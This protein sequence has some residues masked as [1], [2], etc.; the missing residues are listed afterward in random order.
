VRL[1][2]FSLVVS[3]VI[4]GGLS[5]WQGWSLSSGQIGWWIALGL[6]YSLIWLLIGVVNWRRAVGAQ[7][8]FQP[9][10][11]LLIGRGGLQWADQLGVTWDGLSQLAIRR[12]LFGGA[13][14]LDITGQAG[15]SLSLNLDSLD[16]AAGTIDSAVESLSGGTW[17]VDTRRAGN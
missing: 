6:G 9:G 13:A 14:H 10:V 8:S 3:L 16:T 4:L 11:A 17:H 12:G 7:R 1:R 5:I 2:L 15:Q